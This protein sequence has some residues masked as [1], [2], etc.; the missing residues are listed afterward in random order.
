M[1][2]YPE[3]DPITVTLLEAHAFLAGG[4]RSMA[5]PGP[6]DKAMSKIEH[7]LRARKA[8]LERIEALERECEQLRQSFDRLELRRV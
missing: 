6:R 3:D 1:S 4:A 7:A 8:E 5:S 2:V